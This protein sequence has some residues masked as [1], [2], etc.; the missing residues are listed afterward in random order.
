MS[1][2]TG[3]DTIDALYDS[4]P[5]DMH[6]DD[7]VTAF[8]KDCGM[9]EP[10]PEVDESKDEHVV[11][12]S[13]ASLRTKPQP[14]LA[15][16]MQSS[17]KGSPNYTSNSSQQKGGL[18][19]L[20]L[21]QSKVKRVIMIRRLFGGKNYNELAAGEKQ[22]DQSSYQSSFMA[23]MRESKPQLEATVRFRKPQLVTVHEVEDLTKRDTTWGDVWD[24]LYYHGEDLAEFRHKAFLEQCQMEENGTVEWADNDDNAA[25][26]DGDDE[27]TT[28]PTTT[29][30]T[31]MTEDA[32]GTETTES[33][34]SL[35]TSPPQKKSLASL[36]A[37]PGSKAT[38]LLPSPL[39]LFQS[40][41][42]RVILFK[43]MFGGKNYDQLQAGE[44]QA[45][46][47]SMLKSAMA[48]RA[49]RCPKNPGRVQFALQLCAV[50]EIEDL[51][52]RDTSWGDVW[53][54][55]YL[56]EETL[57]EFKYQAFLEQCQ[58]EE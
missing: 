18:S 38:K 12:S 41:V 25:E 55:L 35:T 11:D 17:E 29:S 7:N 48:N 44:Q 57:A 52:K 37:D 46:V 34:S 8:S 1:T 13:A 54:D 49:E 6:R 51:T 58:L 22:A 32:D 9:V 3:N 19:R 16:L 21:L 47:S 40:K 5:V 10:I 31:A 15:V 30:T 45:D 26:D 43:R 39:H 33:N 56:D 20:H 4:N 23:A 42:K 28:A 14:K 27:D 2:S 53:D 24:D 36:A 50:Q